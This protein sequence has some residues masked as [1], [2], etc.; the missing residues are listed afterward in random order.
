MTTQADEWSLVR[1]GR[2]ALRILPR[3]ELRC[4]GCSVCSDCCRT[5]PPSTWEP[6]FVSMRCFS[7]WCWPPAR[8]P[9]R[10]GTPRRWCLSPMR[11]VGIVLGVDVADFGLYKL[12][13]Y[14]QP[15]LAAAVAVWIS[16]TTRRPISGRTCVALSPCPLSSTQHRYVS[17]SRDPS[18][19]PNASGKDLLPA[20]RSFVQLNR[21]IR[22]SPSRRIRLWGS[23]RPRSVGRGRSTSSAGLFAR[24]A[25]RSL[26]QAV[27]EL[28]AQRRESAAARQLGFAVVRLTR[29]RRGPCESIRRTT[30]APRSSLTRR[31]CA[32][33]CQPDHKDS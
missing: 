20:F 23:S 14:V 22:S 26:E 24:P 28:R 27:A 3:S 18:T 4:Q 21:V 13:M 15:F 6:S 19:Y 9:G 11:S 12:Y 32:S 1:F 8:L 30:A 33:S 17:D 2:A 29:H 10:R 25:D 7:P 31:D 16:C 5:L